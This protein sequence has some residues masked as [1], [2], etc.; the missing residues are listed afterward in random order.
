MNNGQKDGIAVF[1]F[2]LW[3]VITAV[4]VIGGVIGLV[5]GICFIAAGVFK[6][7]LIAVILLIVSSISAIKIIYLIRK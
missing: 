1:S 5:V 6:P 2:I 7:I 4:G 3:A